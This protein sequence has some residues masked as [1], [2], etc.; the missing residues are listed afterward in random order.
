MVYRHDID[1]EFLEDVS[2]E[3]LNQLVYILTHDIKDNKPRWA[4]KLTSNN[5]Y[6]KYAPDH[7]KYWHLIAAELQSFGANS[8]AT[9]FRRGKGVEY[10]EILTD[11][12]DKMNVNYNKKDLISKIEQEL[13]AKVLET[14][15]EEMTSIERENF[16][17]GIN[18]SLSWL[19]SRIANI[20]DVKSLLGLSGMVGYIVART[21]ATVAIAPYMTAG[22]VSGM[23]LAALI[24]PRVAALPI[25][26]AT[27]PFLIWQVAGEAYRVT[28]PACIL[29]AT[30]RKK[31][32]LSSDD[33]VRIRKYEALIEK[34]RSIIESYQRSDKK[35][36]GLY[37]FASLTSQFIESEMSDDEIKCI[38][39]SLDQEDQNRIM[40]A[41]LNEL[42]IIENFED[43]IRFAIKECNCCETDII[44]I[45]E[46]IIGFSIEETDKKKEA[47]KILKEI[48]KTL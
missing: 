27:M 31:Y 48:L 12:C 36:F 5:E 40:N 9:L 44:T 42:K 38:I 37:V 34:F 1:L 22:S 7:H 29:V 11:V 45:F 10:K 2:S 24:L 32:E 18:T 6:K 3:D 14:A 8:V 30:L 39:F 17:R 16:L 28:I 13:L 41:F 47:S 35:K 26:I 21:A 46:M 4:E 25:A 20:A 43:S 19:T 33:I 23:V 15:W